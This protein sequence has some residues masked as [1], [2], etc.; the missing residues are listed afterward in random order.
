MWSKGQRWRRRGRQSQ[1]GFWRQNQQGLLMPGGG[2]L[3]GR[4][5][6]RPPWVWPERQVMGVL[7]PQ[8]GMRLG[9]EG[10]KSSCEMLRCLEPGAQGGL[11]RL[12]VRRRQEQSLAFKSM[13]TDGLT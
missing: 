13:V 2:G 11:S 10:I 8:V 7:L 6:G 9:R 3:G 12:Q 4:A 1:G 5:Q